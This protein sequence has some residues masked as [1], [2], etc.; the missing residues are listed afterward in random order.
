MKRLRQLTAACLMTAAFAAGAACA[1]DL[2]PPAPGKSPRI[3]QIRKN[4]ALRVGVL[5]EP[6]W[7]KENVTGSGEPYE[8]PAWMLAKA[9]ADKLGV[10][11]DPVPVSHETKVPILASG[12]VDMTIAPLSE[13]EA[14][15]KVVDFVN[16]STSALC[17]FG[18]ADNPKLKARHSIDDLNS[19]DITIAYFTGTP[20]ETWLPVRL[21][22]AVRRGIPGSGA[23]APVEEIMSGRGDV[24]PID[25]IAWFD[26]ERKL[27]NLVAFPPG[28]KCLQ[29]T[30][31]PTKVGLAIDKNQPDYLNW[32][33]RVQESIEPQLQADELR[34]VKE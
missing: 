15:K 22:K 20:P 32:L 10:K 3:D 13:T 12:Q 18:K 28:D 21:P 34:V 27:P 9:Y 7:L 8:G 2:N 4:G 31:L 5:A 25:K 29:S 33:T 23:N 30:E 17:F 26:L 14:R 16:Y 11:L 1:D 6:P 24:A 19:P